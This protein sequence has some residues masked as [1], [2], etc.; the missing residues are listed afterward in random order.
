MDEVSDYDPDKY[1]REA[2]IDKNGI[3]EIDLSSTGRMTVPTY[4]LKKMFAN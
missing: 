1:E 2:F 3:A 4:P